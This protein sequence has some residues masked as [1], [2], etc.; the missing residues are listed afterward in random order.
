MNKYYVG[1]HGLKTAEAFV[2]KL[3]YN[4]NRAD[5]KPSNRKK[6]GGKKY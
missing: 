6:E 4:A 1:G 3:I 2:D 5:H